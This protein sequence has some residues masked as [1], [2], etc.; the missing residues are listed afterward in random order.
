VKGFS[1]EDQEGHEGEFHKKART[2]GDFT[3]RTGRRGVHRKVRK[4]RKIGEAGSP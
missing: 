4:I 3:G 1:Q 2:K